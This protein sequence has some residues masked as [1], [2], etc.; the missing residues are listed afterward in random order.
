MGD[1][2]ND[3]ITLEKL[4]ARILQSNRKKPVDKQKSKSE[5]PE[6]QKETKKTT[7][8]KKE[9]VKKPVEVKPKTKSDNEKFKPDKKESKKKE[10]SSGIK[11]FSDEEMEKLLVN[12]KEKLDKVRH[13]IAKVVVGQAKVVDSVLLC[14]V[15]DGH[16]LLEGVPG[17]AKSL[18]VETVSKIVKDV[19]YRRIQFVPDMLPADLLGVNTYNPKTGE[20]NI[21]KGPIFANCL[22][23]DEINRAPPKTQAAL[24]ECMQERKVNIARQ[25]FILEKPFLVLA[26]QNPLEQYGTYPLPEA[27]VDRFFLKIIVDYPEYED[28]MKIIDINTITDYGIFDNLSRVFEKGDIVKLHHMVRNIHLSDE[29][30]KYILD[31][32]NTT[33][34]RTNIQIAEMKYVK[35]GGSPRASILL[36]LA[37]RANAL[38]KGRTYVI[39]DDI[40]D[41]AIEVM[42]HRILLNYE[43]KAE[44]ITSENVI[45]AVLD[46]V[47]LP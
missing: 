41:V 21:M 36:A 30:K 18:L 32:V 8:E 15:C 43:G 35:Y 3:L 2:E 20:F 27:L 4:Q 37:S 19:T 5:K 46:N 14:L 25:E 24:L 39:P 9:E 10:A 11:S 31:I 40:K 16:A 12:Y 22:L 6:K 47:P 44:G 34:K 42:R 26:T 28:E 45:K 1:D 17:L 29:I 13:E 33:R 7:E 38:M 23:A